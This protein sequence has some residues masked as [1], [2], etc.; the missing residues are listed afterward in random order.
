M[1]W[2]EPD[3]NKSKDK[4]PWS[5]KKRQEGSPPDLDEAF[6][7]FYGR[8]SGLLGAK[9]GGSGRAPGGGS[10][11]AS[12]MGFLGIGLAAFVLLVIWAL[13]G[14]FIVGPADQ[15]VVLRFGRYV[16]TLG[17]GPHWLP[18][19]I[20]KQTTLDVQNISQYS[21]QAQMLTEDE[22]IV[23]VSIAIQYRIGNPRNYLY[24]VSNSSEVI[25]QATASALRQ[26]IG[27]TTLDDVLTVGREEARV[28]VEKQ[29]KKIL[30]RYKVGITITNVA[31]QPAKA[32]EEVKAAFDDA[33]KAQEDEQRF[34]NQ[35]QA[36]ALNVVPVAEGK[37]SRMLAAA[38]AYKQQ[39]VLH[40]NADV[41]RFNAIES[42]YEKSPSITRERLYLDAMQS[43]LS[44]SSKILLDT[45]GGNNLLYLPL[46]Q[47]VKQI[48]GNKPEESVTNS[49][50]LASAPTNTRVANV[51]RRSLG[52]YPSRE[53][54][55]REGS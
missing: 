22:N 31:M 16:E 1:V 40:A 54:F 14:I 5:G 23:S 11:G 3:D 55:N 24:N 9:T 6:K 27:H 39:V 51:S 41:A 36:Y 8:I 32:P 25:K 26:V 17:P 33:I 28:N 47:M 48:V 2:N 30:A 46:N 35:A 21:Y 12:N 29:L 38:D 19:F 18:H 15:S 44:H 53:A 20:E 4:D 45:K 7:R 52:S 37:A 42:I 13:S 10:S 50:S 34:I 49:P 43:V